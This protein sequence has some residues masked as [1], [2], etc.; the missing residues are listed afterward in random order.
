VLELR[1]NGNAFAVFH[2]SF[3]GVLGGGKEQVNDA[4]H[5][6]GRRALLGLRSPLSRSYEWY[7]SSVT[8]VCDCGEEEN[9]ENNDRVS[10][11]AT[12]G[13]EG[14]EARNVSRV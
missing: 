3:T 10:Y 7:P 4:H 6:A 2:D 8:L 11:E 5:R 14:P 12:Q 1:S 9:L 13:T